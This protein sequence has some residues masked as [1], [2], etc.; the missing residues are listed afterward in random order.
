MAVDAAALAAALGLTVADAADDADP[1]IVEATRLLDLAGGL[2]DAYLRGGTAPETIRDESIIR[3]AGHARHGRDGYGRVAGRLEVGGAV[4][5][6]VQPPAV[7]PVRQS[8]AAALLS[9]Y[10]RRTA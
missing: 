3:T 5:M 8:G 9:P 7:S 10:V 6:N 4:T 2:V 1:G